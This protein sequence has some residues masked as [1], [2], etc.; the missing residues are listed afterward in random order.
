MHLIENQIVNGTS[1]GIDDKH[2]V[3]CRFTNCALLYS[4]GDFAWT[5]TQFENC[6]LQLSGAATRTVTF[7]TQLG[8]KELPQNA[9]QPQGPT[10][11]PPKPN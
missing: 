5:N 8:I 1:V 7:L 4:G 2:F 3:N 10:N 11:R 9:N 6:N